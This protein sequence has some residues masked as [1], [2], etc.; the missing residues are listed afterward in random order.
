M[1]RKIYI[2]C[3]LFL[4]I[5]LFSRCGDDENAP[6]YA[7]FP[8]TV[9]LATYADGPEISWNQI[10]S[11]DFTSYRIWRSSTTDTIP[12]IGSGAVSTPNAF[13][14]GS[15]EDFEQTTFIDQTFSSFNTLPYYYYRVEA[16]LKNRSIWSRNIKNT[17]S[18]S[19]LNAFVNA[20]AFDKATKKIYLF[21]QFSKKAIKFDSDKE[22]V[23]ATFNL[24]STST[25]Y[26]SLGKK[27]NKNELYIA[28]EESIVVLDADNFTKIDE[29]DLN[30]NIY[31][32]SAD[33]AG[34]IFVTGIDKLIIVDRNNA[35]KQSFYNAAST[36]AGIY[37]YY[38]IP[39]KDELLSVES[40]SKYLTK[41]LKLN[42]SHTDVIGKEVESNLLGIAV[43][44]SLNRALI[45][46]P[47]NF[48][49]GDKGYIFSRSLTNLGKLNG[50]LNISTTVFKDIQ[51]INSTSMIAIISNSNSSSS[52]NA[53]IVRFQFPNTLVEE[54]FLSS[55]TTALFVIPMDDKNW[56]VMNK[57]NS[58]GKSSIAKIR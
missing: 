37:K 55:G 16:V 1:F 2:F 11:S 18:S 25:I 29:I 34:R 3:T 31:H 57:S 50:Q 27:N 21:D 36:G 40:S 23:E 48:V 47:D 24:P 35:N 5:F 7:T 39:G 9:K 4:S 45:L 41:I 8:I 49:L 53:S 15:I 6:V 26:T 51:A 30:E 33:N 58:T 52:L 38:F 56:L 17:E 28:Q 46:S 13:V 14:I 32:L 44:T 10:R 19:E 22:S 20:V 42:V 54:K 12:T 43:G